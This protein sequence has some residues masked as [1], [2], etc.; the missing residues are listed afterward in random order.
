ME[1]FRFFHFNPLTLKKVQECNLYP[2]LDPHDLWDVFHYWGRQHLYDSTEFYDQQLAAH[3]TLCRREFNKLA[4][5]PID[6]DPFE[7]EDYY[8]EYLEFRVDFQVETHNED[9]RDTLSYYRSW[10]NEH[11]IM[12]LDWEDELGSEWLESTGKK[13]EYKKRID[14]LWFEQATLYLNMKKQ[15]EPARLKS[16][17]DCA[18]ALPYPEY[19]KT[20]H[21]RRVRAAMILANRGACQR[22]PRDPRAYDFWGLHV[23][24]KSYKS[25][26]NE[27][28]QDLELLCADCHKREHNQ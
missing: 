5:M 23:H 8:D 6:A 19:L 14:A 9:H 4:N 10:R 17:V 26:G 27:Q 1:A 16:K 15:Y 3:E 2:D 13:K 24:H 11:H 20:H 12:P 25:F 28:F 18:R 22:C 7:Y 21:W